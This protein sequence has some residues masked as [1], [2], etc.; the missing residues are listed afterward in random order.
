MMGELEGTS[1]LIT[2][3]AHG[4]G[5]GIAEVL[6]REG[7][8]VAITDIDV[9]AA[10]ATARSIT[11]SGGKAIGIA[12][13]VSSASSCEQAVQQ[14][15]DA[16]GRIDVLVNNAGIS[17]RL[18]FREIDERAWDRMIDV[19]LKGV[20]L[21]VQ[22]VL[23][24][25]IERR[26]GRII[27]TAS[28]IGK[29]GALPLFTHYVASK[30]AVVGLTQSLAAE[31]APHNI[32]V[33]AVCPGVVRTPLW[34]PLLASNAKEQGTSVEEAWKQAVAPI[35]LR[36]PQEPEDIGYAVAFLASERA[37]NIT[38]ESINVNGG[39]LMD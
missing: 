15:R 30:F 24:E 2:G 1:A 26:C 32:L 35:P 37:R 19:N 6:A 13:D 14:A 33:N 5:A 3:A 31:L 11:D 29:A 16:F 8:S 25:M 18:P 17:Q 10:R 9:D 27:N 21:M 28:L 4:I 7:A 39:Q 20:Y 22:A 34:E 38:G 12:H 36:R 23:D